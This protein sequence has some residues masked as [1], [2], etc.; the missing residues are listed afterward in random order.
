MN[1]IDLSGQVA[2]VTGGAQGLGLAIARRIAG[3]GASVCLWDVNEAQLARAASDI[4]PAAAAQVVDAAND[5]EGVDVGAVKI[6]L[7]VKPVESAPEVPVVFPGYVLPDE[8][9]QEPS[10]EGS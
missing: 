7:S 8:H 9:C 2:V 1:E 4:G 5:A 6:R 10:H 3:S